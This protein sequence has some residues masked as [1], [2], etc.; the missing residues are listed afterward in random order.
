MFHAPTLLG[1]RGGPVIK[2]RPAGVGDMVDAAEHCIPDEHGLARPHLAGNSLGGWV[3]LGGVGRRGRAASVCASSP[4]GFW[5]DSDSHKKVLGKIR[6]LRASTRVARPD[7]AGSVSGS[8][9]SAASVSVT[10]RVTVTA[11]ASRGCWR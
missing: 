11:S 5:W 2:R 3:A 8:R 4:A 7:R 10:A 9:S 1:H 6:R